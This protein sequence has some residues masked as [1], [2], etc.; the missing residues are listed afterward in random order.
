MR[1]LLL[2][3]AA[4]HPSPR[5]SSDVDATD[6][7]AKDS[8]VWSAI[9]SHPLWIGK[10]TTSPL[11]EIPYALVFRTE[12][13]GSVVAETPPPPG[14]VLP[15]GAYQKFIFA[16]KRDRLTYDA[17]L[18]G[19]AIKG[20]LAGQRAPRDQ[21]VYCFAP[22]CPEIK[23]SWRVVDATHLAFVTSLHGVVH[24]D[25]ALVA[26]PSTRSAP[27]TPSQPSTQS[28]P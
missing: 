24:T 10:A 7:D 26:Q 17:S 3:L 18:E 8:A 14:G 25:I 22:G 16:A 5:A 4:C 21:L 13:D 11:G 9:A 1:R 27:S 12:A 6:V 28:A 20:S 19:K 15:K 23:V 2:V